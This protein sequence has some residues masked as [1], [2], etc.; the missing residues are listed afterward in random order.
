MDRQ[1]SQNLKH[2]WSEFLILSLV[3][4]AQPGNGY[5]DTNR[6]LYDKT[7]GTGSRKR[8]GTCNTQKEWGK[9]PV[10]LFFFSTFS[11]SPWEVTIKVRKYSDLNKNKNT[12]QV[13]K[14]AII[15]NPMD[16]KR[17]IREYYEQLLAHKF[18]ILG[19]MDQFLGWHKDKGFVP[20]FTQRGNK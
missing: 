14:V 8:K 20:K 12:T 4:F 15:T 9:S 5:Q 3:S 19:E 7:L 6:K 11:Y 2:H 13:M 18:N 17:I 10:Y 1:E 16:V